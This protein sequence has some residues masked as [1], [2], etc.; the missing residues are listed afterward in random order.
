[1][2]AQI[3]SVNQDSDVN[4]SLISAPSQEEVLE[5]LLKLYRPLA[6]NT[7]LEITFHNDEPKD[8]PAVQ[9]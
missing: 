9:S 8:S 3:L 4:K 2:R 7:L 6:A 5:K 1:M